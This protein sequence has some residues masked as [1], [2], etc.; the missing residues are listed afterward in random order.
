ME[1]RDVHRVT[2]HLRIPHTHMKIISAAEREKDSG[3]E[4]AKMKEWAGEGTSQVER[5]K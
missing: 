3:M 5:K 1:W 4:R 2:G